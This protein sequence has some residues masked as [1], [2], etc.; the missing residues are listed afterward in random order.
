MLA[1]LPVFCSFLFSYSGRVEE[2]WLRPC[3]PQNLKYMPSDPYRKSL[4]TLDLGGL[5]PWNPGT[6]NSRDQ[7]PPR[8]LEV[9]NVSPPRPPAPPNLLNQKPYFNKLLEWFVYTLK[10]ESHWLG[11]AM[12]EGAAPSLV[13]PPTKQRACWMLDLHQPAKSLLFWWRWRKQSKGLVL[14]CTAT[15]WG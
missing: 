1:R 4:L 5:G 6:S 8:S 12:G 9:Q 15:S 14:T 10:F 11:K 3:G 13:S 7:A 2:L